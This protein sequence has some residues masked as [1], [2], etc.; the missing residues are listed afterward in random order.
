MLELFDKRGKLAM[1][2]LWADRVPKLKLRVYQLDR[3]ES[4]CIQHKMHTHLDNLFSDLL[5]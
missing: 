1:D 5:L 3:C 4:N 2:G